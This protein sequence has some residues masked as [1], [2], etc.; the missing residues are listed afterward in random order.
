M[1]EAEVEGLKLSDIHEIF[2]LFA[3]AFAE[4]IPGRHV[5]GRLIPRRIGGIR[6]TMIKAIVTSFFGKNFLLYGIRKDNRLVC[7][8]LSVDSTKKSI[9]S[10]LIR[11]IFAL[12]RYEERYLELALLGTLPAYQRRGF[13]R[14]MLQFLY[15]E[16]KRMNYKGIVLIV[17]RDVPAFRLYLKE[18]FVVDKELAVGGR[19]LCRM[20]RPLEK[21]NVSCV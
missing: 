19:R 11:F 5:P 14:R 16:A 10:A 18:G 7:A 2:E 21:T 13:G 9:A 20:R 4:H 1:E 8:S 17:D 6:G 15:D 12:P 3:R